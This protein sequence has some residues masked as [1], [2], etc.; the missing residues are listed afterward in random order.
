MYNV[1]NLFSPDIR[2]Q[3]KMEFPNRAN[4]NRMLTSRGTATREKCKWCGEKVWHLKTKGGQSLWLVLPQSPWPE[5]SCFKLGK[6]YRKPPRD[7]CNDLFDD[8]SSEEA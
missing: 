8:L 3:F 2:G 4:E 1:A 5:H 7:V 6:G